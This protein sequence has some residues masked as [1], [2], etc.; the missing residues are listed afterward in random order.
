MSLVSGFQSLRT[1][2]FRTDAEGYDG[3]CLAL[4]ALG[5]SGGR[6]SRE[7]VS[8]FFTCNHYTSFGS[9]EPSLLLVLSAVDG[10]MAGYH[11]PVR[12]KDDE[13][14]R[15]GTID[16]SRRFPGNRRHNT[17]FKVT[18]GQQLTSLPVTDEVS[19]RRQTH[20]GP[21]SL[22]RVDFTDERLLGSTSSHL[23]GSV[24]VLG[25]VCPLLQQLTHSQMLSLQR[26][27]PLHLQRLPIQSTLSAPLLL[28]LP[29]PQTASG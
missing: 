9:Q 3:Q 6:Q 16:G 4:K 29:Q 7:A 1:A 8:L 11:F 25:P 24:R 13:E 28:L 26:H 22:S 5:Q 19:D 23:S 2:T 15:R 17:K 12:D 10:N 20:A 27:L 18:G 14:E 21:Q